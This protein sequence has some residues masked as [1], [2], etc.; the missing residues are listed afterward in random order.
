[1]NDG[2]NQDL[3]MLIVIDYT[4]LIIIIIGII[5]LISLQIYFHI[6]FCLFLIRFLMLRFIIVIIINCYLV[7]LFLIDINR[8]NDFEFD[9]HFG[10]IVVR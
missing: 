1:M 8:F 5:S 6:E 9:S 2:L 4:V 3:N 7:Y 10:S